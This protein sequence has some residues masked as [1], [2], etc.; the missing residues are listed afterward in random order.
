[1]TTPGADFS[2]SVLRA[3]DLLVLTFDFVN[4]G[5]DT[6]SG[7]PPKLSR[8]SAD[9]PAFVVLRFQPQHIAEQYVTDAFFTPSAY[10][11]GPSRLAFQIA[12]D[13]Q[14]VGFSLP[15]L[16][17]LTRQ[18]PSLA[19]N[20]VD[21][22]PMPDGPPPPEPSPL[23]TAIELPYRLF[24]SPDT[25]GGWAHAID[26]VIHDGVAELW[27]TRLGVRQDGSVDETRLPTIRA[28]W[29][30]GLGPEG[31]DS[32]GLSPTGRECTAIS[33]LSSDYTQTVTR[34]GPGFPQGEE[35]PYLPQPLRATR[36]V[37]SA[38]GGWTDI[39]G[40]WDFPDDP[41]QI[42][43]TTPLAGWRQIVAQGRDQYVR[44]VQKGYLYPLGH[45]A[46][47]E[48]VVERALPAGAG[49]EYLR[50]TTLQIAVR[51]SV[52]DYEEVSGSH[53]RNA[54][55][56]MRRAR[57]E[58]LVTPHL[59]EPA[60]TSF[61]PSVDGQPFAFH[62]VGEDWA[63]GQVDLHM[64]LLF[65]PES[66]VGGGAEAYGPLRTVEVRGQQVALAP[67]P[68]SPGTTSLPVQSFDF[69]A[70]SV[71]ELSPPFLPFAETAAVR[72]PAVDHLVGSAAP[73]LATPVELLDP[74]TT[75][76][77]VFARV[78]S[79]HAL[80]LDLPTD[81]AGGL[82]RPNL[83]IGGLSRTLGA[84]PGGLDAL[85][86]PGGK[87]DPAAL[88]SAA[89]GD[90]KLLG[91]ISLKDVIGD[92]VDLTQLPTLSRSTGPNGA[93]V[94]FTWNPPLRDAPPA[95]LILNVG[96]ASALTLRTSI[97][98]PAG[99]GANPQF[100]VDGLLTQ[101]A[102]DF[103]GV[104]RV[105]FEALQFHA[106][107]G[108]KLDVDPRGVRVELRNELQ[109]LNELANI[110]PAN[111]FSDPPALALSPDGVDVGYSLGLPSAGVGMFSLEQV[112][113]SA[114]IT[115][116]FVAKPAAVR[117]AF[118]ERAHPFLVTVAMIG[119]GGF[120]AIE[121]DTA[122][123]RRI[124][125]SIEVGA[126]LT[127]DLGVVSANVHVMAGFYFGLKTG[128]DGHQAI[129]FSAYLRI[130]G[131]VELLG[132]AGISIEIYLAMS[133]ESAPVPRI[134]G[135]ASVVVGVH[136]LMFTTSVHLSTE[137]YF[138]IP[139]RDPSFDDLVDE[140]EWETYCRAFA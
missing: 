93:D 54:Q 9:Q 121:V 61:A 62:V 100:S 120:L 10:P 64:P 118:S 105:D 37:L 39:R 87:V 96:G 134:G 124:E 49:A 69:A 73:T 65:V 74:E 12:D 86:A 3:D 17:A 40:D 128:A 63:G 131:A 46:V 130:G 43:P 18:A 44:V 36:L 50:E 108:R 126:N 132:I 15:E 35:D 81:R 102:I 115:L 23:Q 28:I 67:N 16:L 7:G 82:V 53:P 24:L 41:N 135:R 70:V 122:G 101:F 76:G 45:R 113:F 138:A 84:V 95:P 136:L 66:D 48:K 119:G 5:L 99:S 8:I 78:A 22:V 107:L 38:L 127:V 19:E 116:P 83:G 4:F 97:H 13:V 94:S 89:L 58:T 140:T 88:F 2:A 75:A 14:T 133:Y 80:D 72:I 29:A 47:L 117:L 139:A 32:L 30:R 104:V 91:G 98:L 129:D 59:D 31:P 52:R 21:H 112:A 92:I 57:L 110:L 123:I 114:G 71:P 34:L 137:K 11:A 103:L 79:G 68:P 27:H 90:A 55:L 111:G 33:Y 109:F 56:P 60:G 42:W 20:A 85:T 77:Q 25:A 125:G 106:E 1:M 26:A 51:E 6:A